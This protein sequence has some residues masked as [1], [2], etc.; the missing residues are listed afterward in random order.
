VRVRWV[1]QRETVGG[2]FLSGDW[3]TNRIDLDIRRLQ[4]LIFRT[5]LGI[6]ASDKTLVANIQMT[7]AR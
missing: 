4:V 6:I 3:N 1:V 7:R 2:W 5:L